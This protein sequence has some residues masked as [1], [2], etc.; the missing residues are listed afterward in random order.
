MNDQVQ[1]F[2]DRDVYECLQ[3]LMVPPDSDAN[4]VIRSLLYN[5]GHSSRAALAVK[6]SQQHFSFK[7]ELDR[8]NEGVYDCGGCT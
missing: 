6:A 4:A 1:I 3:T 8:A 7:Q 2:I 5:E